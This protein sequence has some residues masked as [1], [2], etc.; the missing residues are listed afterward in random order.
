M[1]RESPVQQQ[2]A[3]SGFDPKVLAILG[4]TIAKGV[5]AGMLAA[6]QEKTR[7]QDTRKKVHRERMRSQYAETEKAKLIKWA[8]CSHMRSHPY[9]GTSRIA[10]ATQSDGVTRGTCM[11]CECPFSPVATELPFP[12][13][14]NG[15]YEKMIAVPMTAANNDFIQG[16]VAT[17]T[18]A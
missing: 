3:L 7:E 17:G 11:R 9:S 2:A 14:M 13:E 4:E 15:W 18:P 8:N 16:M 10:W 6:E 5:V 1:E 12:K